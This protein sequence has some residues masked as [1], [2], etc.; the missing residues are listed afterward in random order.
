M[1]GRVVSVLAIAVLIS[2]EASTHDREFLTYEENEAYRSIE[3]IGSSL[4]DFHDNRDGY[5]NNI[6]RFV[7]FFNEVWIVN[8]RL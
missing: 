6:L 8:E 7:L 1:I 4:N 3:Q 2:I 5:I